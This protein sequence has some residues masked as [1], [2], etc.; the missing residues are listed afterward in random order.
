MNLQFFKTIDDLSFLI[1]DGLNSYS[2][3]LS[4]KNQPKIFEKQIADMQPVVHDCIQIARSNTITAA[5]L[6]EVRKLASECGKSIT[7]ASR[8][9]VP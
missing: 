7:C 9:P 5:S 3:E 1:F 2:E 8:F 4:L 6:F